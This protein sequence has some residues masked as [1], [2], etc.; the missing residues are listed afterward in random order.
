MPP[1]P[2]G[3]PEVRVVVVDTGLAAET[4][5]PDFAGGDVQARK[6]SGLDAPD[7]GKDGYLD[8]VAGHGTF[9]AGIMRRLAP[10]SRVAVDQVLDTFGVGDDFEIAQHLDAIAASGPLPH[11]VNLSFSGYT[12][13]DAPPP[14]IA[15]A[16]ASLQEAGV[17]VVASAG[18][19]AS[20]RLNWPAALSDV[21]AV[22]ALG[23]QGAAPFSNFGPWVDAC[24]PGVDIVSTFFE[25]CLS[26]VGAVPGDSDLDD[27]EGWARW[28]GTSFSAPIVV[29][30]LA[31][32]MMSHGVSAEDAVKAVLHDPGLFRF[33]GLGTV[34]NE[35]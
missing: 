25:N 5:R 11:I 2:I 33:P 14:A 34:V 17:V 31:R 9:I 15:G 27:F 7:P 22:G 32:H 13:D 1:L 12:I 10:G 20:C 3:V 24:A 16:V 18:N 23:P 4:F 6:N 35:A 29:A 26:G 30:A 19:S 21:I 8:P 28:S